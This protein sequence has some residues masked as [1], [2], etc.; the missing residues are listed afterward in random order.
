MEKKN[1]EFE[2]KKKLHA[3]THIEN[4]KKAFTQKG[5]NKVV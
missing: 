1:I 3:L 2:E 5:R 4:N